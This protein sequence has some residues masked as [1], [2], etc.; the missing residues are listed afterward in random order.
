MK[1]LIVGQSGGPTSVINGSLAGVYESAKKKGYKVETDDSVL[2]KY[3]VKDVDISEKTGVKNADKKVV[4]SYDGSSN[5]TTFKYNTETQMYE[6]YVTK[7]ENICKDHET[8]EVVSTKNIIIEKILLINKIIPYGIVFSLTPVFGIE[9]A[10][11]LLLP[12]VEPVSLGRY[13]IIS[14]VGV[15][16]GS[17][18]A[19]EPVGFFS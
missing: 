1:T 19:V 16:I 2:L 14:L 9:I 5:V 17:S 11:Y 10:E 7:K 12:A 13:L 6:R 8:G 3:N 18:P 4:I 15:I